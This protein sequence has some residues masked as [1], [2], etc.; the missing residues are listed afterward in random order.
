MMFVV[1][2]RRVVIGAPERSTYDLARSETRGGK[3]RVSSTGMR[4]LSCCVAVHPFLISLSQFRRAFPV[5]SSHWAHRCLQN[6][7]RELSEENVPWLAFAVAFTSLLR[8][9][10]FPSFFSPLPV[11]RDKDLK[12]VAT[13]CIHVHVRAISKSHPSPPFLLPLRT[14]CIFLL[15][16]IHRT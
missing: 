12:H 4:K 1:R 14:D 5:L 11:F 16:I 7:E 10:F 15:F 2:E 8:V 6:S 9:F 3:V 13:R